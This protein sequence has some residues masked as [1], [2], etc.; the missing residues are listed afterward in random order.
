MH[1]ILADDTQI[2]DASEQN[3]FMQLLKEEMVFSAGQLL[4]TMIAVFIHRGLFEQVDLLLLGE[5]DA[6]VSSFASHPPLA[7]TKLPELPAMCAEQ[8]NI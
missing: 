2:H 8:D 1:C 7:P 6:E 4:G 3:D 5:A